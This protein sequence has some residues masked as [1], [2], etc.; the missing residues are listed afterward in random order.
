MKVEYTFIQ[1]TANCYRFK[2]VH[3]ET[4]IVRGAS[5][6]GAELTKEWRCLTSVRTMRTC[7]LD[8]GNT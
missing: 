5:L 1:L 3:C 6:A 2:S 7:S 4:I 8:C